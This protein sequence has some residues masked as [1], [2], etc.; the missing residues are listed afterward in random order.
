M[1]VHQEWLQGY[2]VE[3]VVHEYDFDRGSFKLFCFV[4]SLWLLVV[5]RRSLKCYCF[6]VRNVHNGRDKRNN[7]LLETFRFSQLFKALR[8]YEMNKLFKPFRQAS[9][10]RKSNPDDTYIYANAS[11]PAS[12]T[13]RRIHTLSS[14]ELCSVELA[15]LQSL[16]PQPQQQN[17]TN[18]VSRGAVT[19]IP[20]RIWWR[21]N[22]N[23]TSTTTP[24]IVAGIENGRGIAGF[25]SEYAIKSKRTWPTPNRLEH[26]FGG[27]CCRWSSLRKTRPRSTEG[28]SG[29]M[30]LMMMVLSISQAHVVVFAGKEN[31]QI[32]CNTGF[33][34]EYWAGTRKDARSLLASY[35]RYVLL[36]WIF[37][38]VSKD[39]LRGST[40]KRNERWVSVISV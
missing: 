2:I 24:M 38:V 36:N 33:S 9:F 1:V 5:L 15:I 34:A 8:G 39:L 17:V 23:C 18:K 11:A 6:K 25:R 26:V 16:A 30:A 37:C 22:C 13:A 40:S 12:G 7:G 31:S 29:W 35:V 27:R 14:Y 28:S 10:Y 20:A 32:C 4:R 19:M 21:S 3:H